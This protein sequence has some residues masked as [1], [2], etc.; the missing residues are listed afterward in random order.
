MLGTWSLLRDSVNLIL[1]AVPHGIDLTGVRNYLTNI[2]GVQAVHDLHI[3]GLSTQE[4]ALTVHL[5][6]PE[7]ILSN[8][9]YEEINHILHHDYKIQHVTIQVERGEADNLCKLADTC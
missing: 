1:G 7:R 9:D 8:A 3:W 5:V 6:M 4:T 2:E